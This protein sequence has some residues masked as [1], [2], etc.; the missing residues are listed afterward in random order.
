MGIKTYNNLKYTGF[1]VTSVIRCRFYGC[2]Y[3]ASDGHYRTALG[4]SYF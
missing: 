1:Y 3:L 4:R 2:V